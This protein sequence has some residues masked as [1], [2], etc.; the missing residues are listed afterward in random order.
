[1]CRFQRNMYFEFHCRDDVHEPADLKVQ[2]PAKK[3]QKLNISWLAGKNYRNLKKHLANHISMVTFR[4]VAKGLKYRS[5]KIHNKMSSIHDT[6]DKLKSVDKQY[7]HSLHREEVKFSHTGPLYNNVLCHQKKQTSSE[8]YLLARFISWKWAKT[9]KSHRLDPFPSQYVTQGCRWIKTRVSWYVSIMMAIS[10][11]VFLN[12]QDAPK[13][14]LVR[15][16]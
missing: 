13:I 1:M 11:P 7:Y 12:Q 3:V 5:I 6:Q 4:W 10:N 2:C 14:S 16:A 8:K 9:Y 15:G